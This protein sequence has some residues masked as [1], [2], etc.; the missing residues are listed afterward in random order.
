METD[1]LA[2]PAVWDRVARDKRVDGVSP[3]REEARDPR[4]IDD[5]A[6]HV[7]ELACPAFVET[8]HPSPVTNKTVTAGERAIAAFT[9]KYP[10]RQ[11]TTR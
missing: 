4:H 2:Q 11:L 10:R 1:L 8:S 6:A 3:N 5:L 9:S 7:V